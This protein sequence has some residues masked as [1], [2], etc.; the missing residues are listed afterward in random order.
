LSYTPENGKILT[1]CSVIL[2]IRVAKSRALAVSDGA[3]PWA[4]RPP[5]GTTLP[6]TIIDRA[7]SLCYIANRIFVRS[8]IED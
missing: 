6:L 8:Y 5:D 2:S 4:N 1:I 7:I 3:G